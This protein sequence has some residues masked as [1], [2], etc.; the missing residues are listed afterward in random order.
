[1]CFSFTKHCHLHRRS[2]RPLPCRPPWYLSMTRV[3]AFN[4][5]DHGLKTTTHRLIQ[6]LLVPLLKGLYTASMSLQTFLFLS[7]VCPIYFTDLLSSPLTLSSFSG[8]EV[9]VY[10][11]TITTNASGS[12][13][14]TWECFIDNTSIG[15]SP[16]PPMSVNNWILCGGGP[17]QFQDG[18][19]LLTVKANVSNQQTFWFD[20][21][22]YA[23]SANVSLN[24]SLLRI[25]SSDV[26]IHYDSGWQS[27]ASLIQSGFTINAVYTQTNG[28]SL[29]YQFSGS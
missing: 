26:A 13:D 22:Q 18:P 14:P 1:M 17:G 3:P 6:G 4:V 27:L 8:S 2:C 16:A 9:L 19:H 25:D 23:P 7:A 24:Q 15:W 5:L 11:T 29:T 21:I 20:Q 12:Q 10:G 28:T